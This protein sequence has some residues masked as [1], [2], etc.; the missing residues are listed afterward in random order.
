MEKEAW[1]TPKQMESFRTLGPGGIH[2]VILR[3]L[4]VIQVRHF[5]QLFIASLDERLHPARVTSVSKGGDRDYCGSCRPMSPISIELKAP[6]SVM[7]DKTVNNPGENKLMV[8]C[9]HV[10]GIRAHA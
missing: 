6:E 2:P 7:R 3:P 4:A 9:Q 8:V 1:N 5:D 10:F